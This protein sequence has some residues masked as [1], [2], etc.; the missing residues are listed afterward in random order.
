M[1]PAAQ[2][3]AATN[4]PIRSAAFLCCYAVVGLVLWERNAG[5]VAW[6]LLALQFIVYPHT[7][8]WRSR[9]SARPTRAELDNLFLDAALLGAWCAELG[10][11]TWITF[12]FVT[13]TS[14]NAMVNRGAQGFAWSLACSVAGAV[15]WVM[16]R[17]LNYMPATSDVVTALCVLGTLGYVGA[18]GHVVHAQN[19]RLT[20]ARDELRSSEERYRLI[21]ENAGDLIGMVDH[22]GRWIYTSPSY[23]RILDPEDLAP[24]ADA[25]RKVHPDD[26]EHARAAAM[27]T[28]TIVK[29]R[30]FGM[31]LV[32]KDGRVRQYKTWVHGIAGDGAAP[33]SLLVSQDVTDL[34][35]SEE[36][37]L[38]AAHAFEGMTEAIVIT[39]ADGTIVTVNRAFAELTGY[40]RDD[41]LGQPEYT[42]RNALQ[43]AEYYDEVFKTVARDGYWSGT[44]WARRKNGSVYREWRSVR[45]VRDANGAVTH[46]VMV[47]YEVGAPRAQ[48]EVA[49]TT[50]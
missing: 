14:L 10:F 22:H 11:P 3:L 29:P 28:S 37:L 31:R 8:Y 48:G 47:F 17:G 45:A 18:V 44:T 32:D 20:S 4:Y 15:L 36:K 42:I 21:A 23:A 33:R 27:R 40:T 16:V 12:A 39:A 6:T 30:A 26:A 25:F 19:R 9:L 43:S 13:A 1:H 34:R 7:V 24:G 46:L 38:V 41:V 49:S 35:D 5:P 2:G 50:P